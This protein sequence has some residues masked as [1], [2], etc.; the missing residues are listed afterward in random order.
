MGNPVTPNWIPNLRGK[1]PPDLAD[2]V[3]IA[4]NNLYSSQAQIQALA[5]AMNQLKTAQD[6]QAATQAAQQS[7]LASL[8][9]VSTVAGG[10]STLLKSQASVVPVLVGSFAYV[11]TTSSITW[12][13]DGT[14]GSTQLTLLWPDGST[15]QIPANHLAIT[16]LTANTAYFFYPY[17]S[18]TA[19]A[20]QFAMVAG[21]S[22][23]P[24]AAYA[25][26][27]LTAAA[28]V[29]ADGLVA[30]AP[31]SMTAST[32]SS[33]SGGGSGG[34]SGCARQDMQIEA[35]TSPLQIRPLINRVWTKVEL[36]SG[37]ILVASPEHGVFTERLGKLPLR[38]LK[39]G[40]ILIT[41][42]GLV[43]VERAEEEEY[44][45]VALAVSALPGKL[46]WANGILSHNV[47]PVK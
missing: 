29:S 36:A 30:L 47:L 41:K 5:A 34:G 38:T 4:Y 22:G 39:K 10:S 42:E 24:P 32:T 45:E 6:A 15:S 16:G 44:P 40:D 20:V 37:R 17:S 13:W 26:K 27:N 7:A 1:Y 31:T 12:Y 8:S 21:G 25:A 18:S 2:A 14:N 9:A 11:S 23:T 28:Y 43:P 19:I 33:G 35:L 3:T 46:Y